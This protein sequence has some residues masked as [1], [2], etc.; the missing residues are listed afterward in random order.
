MFELLASSSG[1]R[2]GRLTLPRGIVET[3]VF[4][5]V[6]TSGSV[7]SM[8]SADLTGL[9]AEIILGNTYHLF[10][11]PGL[12]VVSHFKGLHEFISWKRPILT[13]SGGFQ[14]FSLGK[15]VKITEDGVEFQSHLDGKRFIM[16]P[17]SAVEIQ[18][19]LDSDIQMVLDECT[20]Y[21]ATFDYA[22]ESMRRSMRWA[23]RARK[24]A[25]TN[26]NLQFG[27]VQGGVYPQLRRESVAHL[28][29][30]GFDGYAIGGLSVG[31]P[32]HDMYSMSRLCCE[33]LP[34]QK[35]RYLMGVGT[36]LD[37][38]EAV[39]AGV[40]MFDCVMPTRNGRNGFLFTSQG[41]LRIKNA[42]HRYSEEPIDANCSCYTCRTYTRSY[43]RHLFI[44]GELSALRLLTLH[45]LSFYISFMK[46]IRASIH[47]NS[48]AQ[49]RAKTLELWKQASVSSP[50]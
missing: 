25:W 20:P 9:G 10:L 44:A 1:A 2:M 39:A 15:R 27:I 38:L 35:P 49:F 12:E 16:T 5:P 14:A 47:S 48:F 36:P 7:K 29:E 13:D 31:E 11:R 4:M 23:K 32:K 40:D 43:L 30:I 3:P 26:T 21:P 8:V 17:E 18:N 22:A 33:I 24:L 19:T 6:G 42:C 34:A 45:N 28:I 50:R 37:I 41:P 46:L